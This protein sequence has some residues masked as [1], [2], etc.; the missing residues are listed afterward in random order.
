MG[1]TA[2][3]LYLCLR[4]LVGGLGPLVVAALIGVCGLQQ[5]MMVVPAMYLGSG[6]VFAKV[7]MGV[8]H[9]G[10]THTLGGRGGIES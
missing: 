4:N 3:A 5:A 9:K 10:R 7:C 2:S 8:W 6:V 1:S